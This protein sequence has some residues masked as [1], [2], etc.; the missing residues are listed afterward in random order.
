MKSLATLASQCRFLCKFQHCFGIGF[1]TKSR[2]P[3]K[4][5]GGRVVQ[6]VWPVPW[7]ALKYFLSSMCWQICWLSWGDHW[8]K[9]S[10]TCPDFELTR[11]YCQDVQ[12]QLFAVASAKA[13]CPVR[14]RPLP[15]FSDLFCYMQLAEPGLH[16]ISRFKACASRP[17][18]HWSPS[19]HSA[20]GDIWVFLQSVYY[21]VSPLN[22]NKA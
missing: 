4:T 1:P 17:G 20:N 22:S 19:C 7:S 14:D 5:E 9:L 10:F 6:F 8:W 21:F 13:V 11:M 16:Q 18:S 12:E 2:F 15:K 3:R